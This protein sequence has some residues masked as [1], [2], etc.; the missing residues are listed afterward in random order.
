M[1]SLGVLA[2]ANFEAAKRS[3]G[4]QNEG[5]H[6]VRLRIQNMNL[7]AGRWQPA[8]QEFVEARTRHQNE[9]AYL[10]P[11]PMESGTPIEVDHVPARYYLASRAGLSRLGLGCTDL[12]GIPEGKLKA[13]VLLSEGL[14]LAI[15]GNQP[16]LGRKVSFFQ[17]QLEV[18]GTCKENQAN[19]YFSA[20]VFWPANVVN[21]LIDRRDKDAFRPNESGGLWE[22]ESSPVELARLFESMW[23]PE[24]ERLSLI[25]W[26]T[27]LAA[28]V[29]LAGLIATSVL[30]AAGSRQEMALRHALGAEGLGLIP[31]EGW[32]VMQLVLAANGLVCVIATVFMLAVR[33]WNWTVFIVCGTSAV[34][35]AVLVTALFVLACVR[36]QRSDS[37]MGLLRVAES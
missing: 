26:L 30:L 6:A 27:A 37:V 9:A 25:Y 24:E 5:L 8:L 4:L 12:S 10:W 3:K 7:D 2:Q 36:V 31:K 32:R 17:K 21:L 33:E 29:A 14:A 15:S 28:T 1:L 22:V 18:L 11:L 13:G 34:I 23:L 19:P 35:E 16:I 20:Y